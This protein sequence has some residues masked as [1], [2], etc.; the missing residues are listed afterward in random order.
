LQQKL[1]PALARTALFHVDLRSASINV[2]IMKNI[3]KRKVG[4][5][6][7]LLFYDKKLIITL[8]F[9]KITNFLKKTGR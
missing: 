5:K 1:G 6:Y 7:V 2:T 3:R 4:S 9:K 8:A